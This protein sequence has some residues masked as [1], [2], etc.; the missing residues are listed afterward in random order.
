MA[1]TARPSEAGLD[2]SA[3]RRGEQEGADD[4]VAEELRPLAGQRQDAHAA[5][6]VPGQH[7]RPGRGDGVEHLAEVAAGAVDRGL[8]QLRP[9][10]PAVAA[11]VPEHQPRPV[12]QR[13]PLQLPLGQPGGEP[14]RE[15]DGERGVLVAVDLDV[16][17]DAVVGGRRCASPAAGDRSGAGRDGGDSVGTPLIP[18]CGPR[19]RNR[20][21]RPLRAA[22]G[23]PGCVLPH[24]PAGGV[25]L[26]GDRG[27][28]AVGEDLRVVRDAV[29]RAR[30]PPAAGSPAA[31][32]RPAPGRGPGRPRAWR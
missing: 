16:Q 9:A 8:G 26:A 27:E 25:H 18:G 14:V 4:A 1:L 3:G 11:L 29:R 15:D 20:G 21:V 12:P 23:R 13:G 5:H 30:P 32:R 22:S 7:H 10:R 31:A 17:R 19:A 6:R 2:Q 28:H 24:Q